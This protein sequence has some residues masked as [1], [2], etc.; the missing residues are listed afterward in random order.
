VSFEGIGEGDAD[1]AY[2]TF[3]IEK[4]SADGSRSGNVEIL[5]ARTGSHA[6]KIDERGVNQIVAVAREL[7][8]A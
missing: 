7:C 4:K 1:S 3:R 8:R 6:W 2:A 5:V